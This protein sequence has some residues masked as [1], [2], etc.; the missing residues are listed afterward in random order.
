MAPVDLKIGVLTDKSAWSN[1]ILWFLKDEIGYP[2]ETT[3]KENISRYPV[4]IV[5]YEMIS[6]DPSIF[7]NYVQKKGSMLVLNSGSDYSEK[8]RN[9]PS[10][11]NPLPFAL[12]NG[13]PRT[14]HYI[15]NEKG[16]PLNAFFPTHSTLPKKR[17]DHNIT[18]TIGDLQFSNLPQTKTIVEFETIDGDR[19]PLLLCG[20]T[21]KSGRFALITATDDD[22]ICQ[23]SNLGPLLY[24]AALEWC[25]KHKPF[26]RKWPWPNMKRM[27]VILTFDF[28][29]LA[30]YS[31]DRK[32]T[33][34]W[35]WCRSF[36]RFLL[37]IG[38]RPILKFL[39]EKKI[40]STWFVVGSQAIH[41]PN[42]VRK[43][44][45]IELVEIAGHGD[46][47]MDI[48]KSA[49][50]FDEDS[51]QI[52]NRRLDAMKQMIQS[53]V[54]V[55][56]RGFRAPGLYADLNTLLALE[57]GGF[58]WDCS[59]S[60]QTNI[61]TRWL[62]LPYC[63]IID[64]EKNSD[65]N[66]VEIPV[67]EP[68]D[69][70]CPIHGCAHSPRE[71]FNE[72]LED[73]RFLFFIGGLQTLLVHPYWIVTHKAW[74][75]AAE[76]FIQKA[77][78]TSDVAFSTCSD[79]STNWIAKKKMSLEATYD[80]SA[81]QIDISINNGKSGLSI[82]A[83]IPEDSEVRAVFLNG[84]TPVSFRSWKDINSI[85]FTTTAKRSCNYKILL[86]KL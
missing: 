40:P 13:S 14:G 60:P 20:M 59:A 24:L 19:Y 30:K 52:Q 4:M 28:E 77:L 7:T 78:E 36:D 82:L 2:T 26:V 51:M 17:K 48:D 64:S 57:Q 62:F 29:T 6:R 43:L 47:H 70:W 45:S 21:K 22:L 46:R 54:Q 15:V 86:S 50:R 58:S 56:I 42:F 35:W 33:K 3:S 67:V 85:I 81:S 39:T 16:N 8:D 27:T 69:Q 1:L 10:K 79:V 5:S 68:W 9:S 55:P 12:I 32:L 25:L 49:R 44:A 65:A 34:Y 75:K 53:S 38:A 23:H 66:L 76:F 73:F 71:Y 74:W 37:E 41:T 61:A 83:R 11:E 84:T 31:E 72:L 63:P 18:T 80:A